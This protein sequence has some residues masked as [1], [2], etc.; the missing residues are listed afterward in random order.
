VMCIELIQQEKKKLGRH[1]FGI[2]PFGNWLDHRKI[3]EILSKII[4]RTQEVH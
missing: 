4:R 1:F 2:C 3:V